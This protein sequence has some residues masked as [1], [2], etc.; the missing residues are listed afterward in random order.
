MPGRRE[1]RVHVSSGSVH[2]MSSARLVHNYF[3]CV[4]SLLVWFHQHLVYLMCLSSCFCESAWIN[5][6]PC[7]LCKQGGF[8]QPAVAL[9]MQNGSSSSVLLAASVASAI[10]VT[11]AAVSIGIGTAAA[12]SPAVAAGQVRRHIEAWLGSTTAAASA[13]QQA[14]HRAGLLLLLELA[15]HLRVH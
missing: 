12:A 7:T 13:A 9:P 10:A 8:Q 5:S 6:V 4:Y 14:A 15:A 3:P 11:T 2:E 1:F